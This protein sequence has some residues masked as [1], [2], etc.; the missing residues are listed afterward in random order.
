MLGL[1]TKRDWKRGRN[2]LLI[3]AAYPFLLCYK[4]LYPS[5]DVMSIVRRCDV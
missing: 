5:A 1:E 4:G 2:L 3:R